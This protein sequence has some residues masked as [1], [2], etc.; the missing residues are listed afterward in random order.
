MSW[1]NQVIKNYSRIG[2]WQMELGNVAAA[3]VLARLHLN[4]LAL[5]QR[6]PK[7]L[8]TLDDW[9]GNVH[10]EW[11]WMYPT[12]FR[13]GVIVLVHGGGFMAGSPLT[14][15]GVAWRLSDAS[16]CR[17][18][19]VDY[20]LAP[21]HPYPAAFDDV[22]AVYR[23]LLKQGHDA[24]HIAFAGDS[25]GGNLALAA[26]LACRREQLPSPAAVLCFSPWT[27]LTQSGASIA[28]NS[29]S[30]VLIP[31]RL[32]PDVAALYL[33]D[34]D[35]ADPA[36]S[37]LF[38]DFTDFPPLQL[39]TIDEEVLRDDTLRLAE[40]AR[41]AG[42]QVDCRIWSGMPHASALFADWL[43]EGREQLREG[44]EFL[45]RALGLPA[46]QRGEAVPG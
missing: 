27:D 16:N 21:E 33:G 32:L 38:G 6:R 15:R 35:P 44:G 5:L 8:R 37:P 39:H 13:H 12:P 20:R 30:E 17:V 43:P 28:H 36:V 7:R 29:H 40:R 11:V 42:A 1:Q 24:A 4:M 45:R 14:H 2:K 31:T 34:H 3:C 26:A 9:I 41:A 19:Q 18:L 25:A 10:C 22:L 46:V 23:A